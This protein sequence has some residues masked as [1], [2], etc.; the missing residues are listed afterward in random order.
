VRT[1]L[2][3]AVRANPG[4]HFR[5][6]QRELDC[7]TST[8]EHHLDTSNRVR[9]H[10]L[11]GYR[12]VY[13]HDLPERFDSPLAALNHEPRGPILCILH[14]DTTASFSDIHGRIDQAPSTVSGH[15]DTLNNAALIT[16]EEDG[17]RKQYRNTGIVTEAIEQHQP[18][19]LD[20]LAD[21]FASSWGQ[22]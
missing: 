19:V 9:D 11:R 15:L 4:I 16:V 12:R 18:S 14:Q 8:V 1:A 6:L 10:R 5:A 21:R 2:V 20:R 3:N 13:P 17:R 7:S 22:L